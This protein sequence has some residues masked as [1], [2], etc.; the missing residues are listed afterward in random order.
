MASR[1]LI[2]ISLVLLFSSSVW[3]G[4]SAEELKEHQKKLLERELKKEEARREKVSM[5]AETLKNRDFDQVIDLTSDIIYD[6]RLKD[7]A[8][9]EMLAM[10]GL[11]FFQ[12]GDVVKAKEDLDKAISENRQEVKAYLIR[13]SIHER[14]N[15]KEQAIADMETYVRLKPN[16]QDGQER[17]QKLKVQT[18]AGLPASTQSGISAKP[19]PVSVQPGD[20]TYQPEVDL[21][22]K[23]VEAPDKSFALYKPAT[24]KVNEDPRPDS[25]RITVIAPDQSAAVDFLWMRNSGGQVNAL[26]ALATYRQRLVP[27]GADIVWSDIYCSPDNSRATVTVRYRSANLS[28]EGRLYLEASTTALSVQ[29]YMAR[30]GLLI[31]QRPM[32][33]N[34]MASL[35]FS[36]QPTSQPVKVEAFTPQYVNAPLINHSA[37]DGSLTMLTPSDWGFV[38]AQGKVITSADNGSQGFAFLVFSGNPILRGATVAQG[39][40]A[41]S[42]MTPSQAIQ[43]ILAG[44]GHRNIKITKS[45]PDP[46]ASQEFSRQVGRHSDA[47]DM[48]VT[49]TSAKGASCLGFF[50]VINA[51]PS[52][53]GL[54]FCML[55]GTWGPQHDFYLYYPMLE[56]VASSFSINDQFARRYIQDGL[57]RA[58]ELHDKTVA[59]MRDNAKGREQQQTDW[60]ARQKQKDFIDSKWD[61]H[62][63][64]NSYW[65]SD[66][67]NGKVYQTDNYG[68]RDKGTN[69]YYEGGGYNYTNFEGRNPRHPSETMREITRQEA[70]QMM[71]K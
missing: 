70:E 11:A 41:Q 13:S 47:Q 33:Y 17:L 30:E 39:V 5:A 1:I 65:V 2:L 46:T 51:A 55:A 29:G 50:K 24:W 18:G 23:L 67:E 52:P 66:L 20:P 54:W 43:V 9:A 42:Y 48:M 60:E 56:Q 31:Q 16:D 62:Q 45:Q 15:R 59:M 61:D 21:A 40:I 64:G 7:T 3:A 4:M 14:E 37:Q 6:Y 26:H 63:R 71:G 68:T 35:A 57:K 34:I 44:F 58:R 19:R 10:R 22:L 69:D 28:L 8:L 38:A 32:L 12:K 53:T 49:W 27:S 36:K 25:M